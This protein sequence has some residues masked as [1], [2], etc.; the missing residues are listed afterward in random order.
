MQHLKKHNLKIPLLCIGRADGAKAAACVN[1]RVAVYTDD[2]LEQLQTL[3]DNVKFLYLFCIFFLTIFLNY[4]K[5]LFEIDS[6]FIFWYIN[7]IL[8]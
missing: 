2:D 3:Q 5:A 4:I 6:A 8:I 7:Y 1:Q